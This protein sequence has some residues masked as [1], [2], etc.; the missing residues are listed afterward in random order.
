MLKFLNKVFVGFNETGSH[1]C[2]KISSAITLRCQATYI[3][4]ASS[5]N[6]LLITKIAL[7]ILRKNALCLSQSAFRNFAPHVISSLNGAE[8]KLTGFPIVKP[9]ADKCWVQA[10]TLGSKGFDWVRR[11]CFG[12]GCRSTRTSSAFR[13]KPRAGFW[14][15]PETAREKYLGIKPEKT[16]DILRDHLVSPQI[17]VSRNERRNSILMTLTI[18]IWIVFL[19]GWSK[20]P[21]RHDQS[22]ALTAIHYDN[23]ETY[24]VLSVSIF[25]NCSSSPGGLWVNSPWGRRPNGLLTQRP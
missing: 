9:R 18:K 15:K 19:T 24:N 11:R 6:A 10:C 25:N 22:E 7:L 2:K 21:T 13:R 5:N 3:Q 23:R 12:V 16:T 17:E 4:S 8:T 20:F 1:C 14:S